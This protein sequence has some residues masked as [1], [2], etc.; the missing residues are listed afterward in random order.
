MV[1]C[2]CVSRGQRDWNGI[3]SHNGPHDPGEALLSG[4]FS[5]LS[6]NPLLCGVLSKKYL[7]FK[8]NVQ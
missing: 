7:I 6:T 3:T 1:R 8:I 5:V 2:E 4:A